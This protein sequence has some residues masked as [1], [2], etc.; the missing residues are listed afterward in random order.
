MET[1]CDMTWLSKTLMGSSG[2]FSVKQVGLRVMVHIEFK[3]ASSYYHTKAGRT[4][5]GRRDYRGQI[6]YFAIYCPDTAKVYLVPLDHVG[7]AHA[8]LRLLPTANRQEKKVRWAKDYE[9]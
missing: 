1:I 3:T 7:T 6:E 8:N 4:G 2:V 5:H 9:L